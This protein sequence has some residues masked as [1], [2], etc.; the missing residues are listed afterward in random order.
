MSG[1][2][3]RPP[4][5]RDER[6]AVA[7]FTA[8]VSVA[9]LACAGLAV[10]LGNTW[11]RRGQLQVQADK[12]VTFAAQFLPAHTE[13]ERLVVAKAVA[14][15]LVC[16][17]VAGQQRHVTAPESCPDSPASALLDDYAR[18]L[19]SSP[20]GAVGQV[21]V[22]VGNQVGVETPAATVSFGAGRVAGAD[23]SLQQ[24]EATAR[25]TSPGPLAPMALSLDCLIDP[26]TV[27]GQG[28]VPFGFVST[29]HRPPQD[30]TAPTPVTTWEQGA[31]GDPQL[32]GITPGR[33]DQDDVGQVLEVSGTEW[34][35]LTA[36][37]R[38]TVEFRQGELR[39]PPVEGTLVLST[40]KNKRRLGHVAV[41]TPPTVL[42]NPGEWQVKVRRET[43]SRASGSFVLQSFVYSSSFST[44]D[45]DP[46][47]VP[48]SDTACGRLLKSP[49]AG[50]QANANLAL[51]LQQ[52][53]DHLIE[54]Y[55][56]APSVSSGL[57]G[58]QDVVDRAACDPGA[59]VVD[60]N[61]S[62]QTGAPPN[63]VVTLMSNAYEAGFT[64]G[65]IGVAGRLTCT[66]ARPCD[67]EDD[68]SALVLDGRRLN[69]DRLTE[70]VRDPAALTWQTFFDTDDYLS[71]DLPTVTPDSP[72]DRT[73]YDSHRFM[74]V[75]VV[76]TASATSAVQ[77]GDHP[78]VAFRPIFV[79][80]R[81]VVGE[82][83]V[84]DPA[85]LAS[86]ES[87]Q[88]R[89]LQIDDSLQGVLYGRDDREGVLLDVNG[90]VSAVRFLTLAPSA[91]PAVPADYDGA[92]SE[93]LGVGPRIVRLVR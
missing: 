32:N 2:S 66:D 11:A 39:V 21:T 43:G 69:N 68:E 73:L 37:Q 7:V 60:T 10:D 88:Q 41:V 29:T 15:Y 78:V 44:V 75:A 24:R 23:Q 8:I 86:G 5:R 85:G 47:V 34:P 13:A 52:G 18:T 57:A 4:R 89:V 93:Y 19:L 55:P 59:R 25:V 50:T 77:A 74:W 35:E 6:G 63:C 27:V 87:V 79:T 76:S 83:P 20:G 31:V 45:V 84:L 1:R 82:L 9:L 70:F 16:N 58:L 54:R 40:V 81:D 38:F 67:L 65:L 28:G 80:Q 71:T 61:G 30:A 42:E 36:D 26:G 62:Q 12:A 91:L 90:R 46:S 14:Y 3:T 53:I 72:F 17:P 56:V 33:V 49:R 92:E 64:D 22:P 51:N 48:T